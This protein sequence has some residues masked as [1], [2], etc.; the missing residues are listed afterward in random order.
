MLEKQTGSLMKD[1]RNSKRHNPP[2]KTK[3]KKKNNN[4]TL[5]DIRSRKKTN[6]HNGSVFGETLM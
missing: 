5:R 2:Q 1:N 6:G 3:N 4:K